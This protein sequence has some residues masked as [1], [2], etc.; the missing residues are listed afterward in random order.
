MIQFTSSDF[1]SPDPCLWAAALRQ[2]LFSLPDARSDEPDATSDALEVWQTFGSS[3]VHTSSAD[4]GSLC[5]DERNDSSTVGSMIR[6]RRQAL[7][8]TQLQ[9]AALCSMKQSR[10]SALER[11]DKCNVRTLRRIAKALDCELSIGLTVRSAA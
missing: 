2:D 3:H 10:I 5:G 9:L 6:A 7:G 8:L 4:S 1:C 11:G